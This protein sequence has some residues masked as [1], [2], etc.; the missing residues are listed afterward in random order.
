MKNYHFKLSCLFAMLSVWYLTSCNSC[1][2]DKPTQIEKVKVAQFGEVFLYM[3]L[4]L[5]DSKGFFREEGIEI[6]L[7]NTGGDDKTFAAIISGSATFGIADPTFVAIAKEKGQGGKVVAS[8]VNGVPFWGVTKN[9]KIPEIKELKQLNGYSVATFPSP[10]T[11]FTL[12]EDMFH[13]GGLKPNIKQGAFGTL[14]PMLEAGQVDIALELE[15]NVSIAVNQGARVLYSFADMYGDF[16]ITGVTVSDET[17]KSRPD[18]VQRFVNALQKAEKYAHSKPDSAIYY[19][20]KRFPDLDDKIVESAMKRIIAT[21]TFPE[22][23]V[24]SKNAWEKAV[25]LR[26][27]VGDIKSIDRKS[28]RLNS[29]HPSISRMPSSA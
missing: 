28:T 15:P 2:S 22:S 7:T 17:I 27:E 25:A 3:P 5:A 11:A 16:A 6:E 20:N 8:V 1:S 13:D 26:I 12:Q 4:Y 23:A 21:K 14:L 18:L 9:P 24:I 10:S 29:S 19:A